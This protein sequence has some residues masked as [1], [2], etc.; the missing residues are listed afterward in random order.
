MFSIPA[1]RWQEIDL[2]VWNEEARRQ[3]ILERLVPYT[4]W[5]GPHSSMELKWLTRPQC[6]FDVDFRSYGL[7]EA[8]PESRVLHDLVATEDGRAHALVARWTVWDDHDERVRRLGAD[9]PYFGRALTWPHYV[10]ALAM[11]GTAAGVLEPIPVRAGEHLQ[12]EVLVR[13]GT[14]KQTG[15]AGPEFSFALQGE[16]HQ[17]EL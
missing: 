2:T 4:K 10:Q 5:F 1:G 7:D 16:A 9:S 15:A 8:I 14:A 11:P 6:V 17:Q 12:L 3:R 13:Q